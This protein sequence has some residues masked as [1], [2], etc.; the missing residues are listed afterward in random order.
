[1]KN[2]TILGS[3]GSIGTSTL[4]VIENFPDDFKVT[5]LTANSNVEL[6][7]QQA[8][9]F[10]PEIVAITNS[11]KA[12]LV[13]SRLKGKKIEVVSGIEGLIKAASFEKADLVVSGIVGS[14]GLIPTMAAIEAGINI[15]LA[16][17]ETL[18]MAGGLILKEAKKRKV[19]IIPIDS[20]HNAIFQCLE[21]IRPKFIKNIILTASGGP[22]LNLEKKFLKNVTPAETVKHPRWK[23]GA[24]ISVDSAT[25]MNKGFEVIEAKYLFDISF[26][27]VKVLIHP[28]S[29]VHGLVEL[30]D[31]NFM[32]VLSRTD[33][34]IPIQHALTYPEKK[35]GYLPSLD[36]NSIKNLSF[37]E[38]DMDRYPCLSYAYRAG[39]TGGTMPAV[40]N[41]ANE[42][43]VHSFLTNK[44]KFTDIS[45]IIKTVIDKHDPVS[46]PRLEEILSADSWARKESEKLCF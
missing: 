5:G 38:P 4:D 13:S 33:M 7:V 32:A 3:T 31:G 46:N 29:I 27:K 23:M 39:I 35:K 6:L 2:I 42:T 41:A 26:D 34:R 36:M 28:E 25:M 24:K 22:F 21:N 8:I 9:K 20:E 18:V 17:K 14:A 15:A 1:M 37:K 16:N 43:A 40:L 10:R 12:K 45:R 30:I 11:E 19:K 44:I